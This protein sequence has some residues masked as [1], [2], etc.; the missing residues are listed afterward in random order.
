MTG[1]GTQAAALMTVLDLEEREPGVFVGQ[2][3]TTRHCLAAHCLQ[4]R[5]SLSARSN[6]G[7]GCT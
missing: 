3:P 2:T 7:S 1:G 6:A 4:I 5:V